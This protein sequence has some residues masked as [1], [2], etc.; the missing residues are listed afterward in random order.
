M[1]FAPGTEHFRLA[2]TNKE[3]QRCCMV[4]KQ[5]MILKSRK[6]VGEEWKTFSS[7]IWGLSVLVNKK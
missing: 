5:T 2:C 7:H 3:K 6:R 4:L 1:Y